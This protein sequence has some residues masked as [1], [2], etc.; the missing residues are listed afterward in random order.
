[1]KQNRHEIAR[2]DVQGDPAILD[3]LRPPPLEAGLAPLVG[4]H[5]P[6]SERA[7]WVP[8]ACSCT[9]WCWSLTV[10][11]PVVQSPDSILE[12]TPKKAQLLSS[13]VVQLAQSPG[14]MQQPARLGALQ[15][16]APLL[17]GLPPPA[18]RPG[19]TRRL[20]HGPPR[21]PAGSC[22]GPLGRKTLWAKAAIRISITTHPIMLTVCL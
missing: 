15:L 3:C 22:S 8:E 9:R 4:A 11:S 17:G 7:Q 10:G 12:R 2:G 1:M 16:L 5:C 14:N 13:V 21:S 20:H 6:G 18:G 19:S